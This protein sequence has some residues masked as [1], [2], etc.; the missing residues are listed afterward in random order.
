MTD[1][2]D[3]RVKIEGVS[4]SSIGMAVAALFLLFWLQNG[5]YR[6]DCALGAAKA[7]ELIAAEKEYTPPA[8]ETAR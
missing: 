8:S 7:C 6:V 2:P 3:Y 4:Y 1:K 5:W